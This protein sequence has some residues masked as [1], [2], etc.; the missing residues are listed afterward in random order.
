MS[1]NKKVNL[2]IERTDLNINIDYDKLAEALIKAQN[3]ADEYA[4]QQLE[5]QHEK[6]KQEWHKIVG[7]KE[8]PK[9]KNNLINFLH[10]AKNAFNAL[11][12]LIFFKEKYIEKSRM[13][14][15]LMSA[16][17]QS[18][19]EIIEDLLNISALT[20]IATPILLKKSVYYLWVY[21]ILLFL[22]SRIVRIAK[23]E[24]KNMKDAEKIAD[25]FSSVMTFV[26]AVMTTIGV[27]IAVLTYLKG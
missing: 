20:L 19:F 22:Y 10:N 11:R 3:K 21:A 8:Y 26:G 27:I 18:V 7:Y 17:A 25:V 16:A 1:K 14:D 13:L 9:S 2:N 5:E 12:A 23:L 4:K 6:A 24:I 15:S